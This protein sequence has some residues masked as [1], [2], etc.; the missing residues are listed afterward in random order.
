MNR[1][2]LR[3]AIVQQILGLLAPSVLAFG[4]PTFML[5]VGSRAPLIATGALIY[6]H[7]VV[8]HLARRGAL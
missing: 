8:R 1:R 4:P 2:L 6:V 3:V 5:F 7:V